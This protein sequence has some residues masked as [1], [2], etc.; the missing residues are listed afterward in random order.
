MVDTTNLDKDKWPPTDLYRE[1]LSQAHNK[2]NITYE[3]ARQKYGLYTIR[4]W[5]ELLK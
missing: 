5:E 2:F 1:Y 4:E 3:E